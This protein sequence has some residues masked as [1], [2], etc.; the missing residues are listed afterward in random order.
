MQKKRKV[1]LKEKRRKR[2]QRAEIKQ[3][4][5]NRKKIGNNEK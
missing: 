4:F 2:G 5:N 1:A 3:P